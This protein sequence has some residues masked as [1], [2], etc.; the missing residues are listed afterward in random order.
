M[1][2]VGQIQFNED[3]TY[4]VIGTHTYAQAGHYVPMIDIVEHDAMTCD[5]LLDAT[6]DVADE[7]L[8]GTPASGLHAAENT[9]FT[10]DIA[11][12]TDDNADAAMLY[13]QTLDCVAKIQWEPGHQ[14]QGEIRFDGLQ[15]KFIISGDYTFA[16]PGVKTVKGWVY[17]CGGATTGE[18]DV[19]LTVTDPPLTVTPAA[20][21]LDGS[22]AQTM[23][24]A[25]FVDPDSTAASGE[26]AAAV[27]WGDGNQVAGWIEPVST[28]GFDVYATTTDS[29]GTGPITV[30][31]QE[32]DDANAASVTDSN[33]QI[34]LDSGGTV[35][36]GDLPDYA[37]MTVCAGTTADLGNQTMTFAAV[38]LAGGTITDGTIS[39]ASYDLQDGEIDAN[40]AGGAATVESGGYVVLT[41]TNNYTGGTTIANTG[42]LAVGPHGLGTGT[43]TIDAG[44]TLQ[45]LDDMSLSTTQNIISVAN[46]SQPDLAA[47]IDTSGYTVT[48]AGTIFGSADL[49]KA[50]DGTLNVSGVN[51]SGFIHNLV[52]QGGLVAAS[53]MSNLGSGGSALVFDGGGLQWTAAFDIPASKVVD[54]RLGGATF[55]TNGH[56]VS[57]A[58]ALGRSGD[59]A[60]SVGGV[61]VTDSDSGNGTLTL[62]PSSAISIG[63]ARRSMASSP[64]RPMRFSAM[65]AGRSSSA[66]RA[67]CARSAI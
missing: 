52:M 54:I 59:F 22:P 1:N 3:G 7:P 6:I 50:G 64:R 4:S 24:V 53:G 47:A 55:D 30:T 38:T 65:T 56:N 31:V 41:G 21:V 67:C 2:G 16:E 19:P 9:Q 11:T 39:A 10:G 33:V 34:V 14:S 13:P 63:A 29:Y 66:I 45:A 25:H 36:L 42:T 12:F 37:P 35:V 23:K 46:T 61:T 62:S 20:I 26:F 51:N 49:A 57:I 17:D 27:D 48:L 18:I 32:D 43:V 44:G 28:G 5:Y 60:N 40:L 8:H 15:N 58:A